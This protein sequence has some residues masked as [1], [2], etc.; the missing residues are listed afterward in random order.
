[1][2]QR[3]AAVGFTA[4]AVESG[5]LT[6]ERG[7]WHSAPGVPVFAIGASGGP[8]IRLEPGVDVALG[9]VHDVWSGTPPE[10]SR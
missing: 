5:S 2:G 8:G 3:R 10:A 9:E 7:R 4:V 6:V 1:M